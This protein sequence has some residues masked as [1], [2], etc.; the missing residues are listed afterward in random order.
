MLFNEIIT[1]YSENRK[2]HTNLLCG[3]NPELLE[4]ELGGTYSF[5]CALNV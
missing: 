4:G 5:Q 1:L 3:W 2:V